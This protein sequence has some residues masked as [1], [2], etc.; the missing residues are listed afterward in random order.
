VTFEV[1]PKSES[2]LVP[3]LI[4]QPLVENSLRHG[5]EPREEAGRI[6]ISAR[7]LNGDTLELKVSDNGAGLHVNGDPRWHRAEQCPLPPY[8]PLR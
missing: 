5:L 2:L 4:L 3:H 8:A 6:T 1:E 7:V